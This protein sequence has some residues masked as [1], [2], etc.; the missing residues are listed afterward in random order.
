MTI[1]EAEVL[2]SAIDDCGARYE[3][4][5]IKR[6]E[7][8]KGSDVTDVTS[9]VDVRVHFTDERDW[10]LFSICS[11]EF[12]NRILDEQRCRAGDPRPDMADIYTAGGPFIVARSINAD[13][14]VRSVIRYLEIEKTGAGH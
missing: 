4:P 1:E 11:V 13:V 3:L 5:G 7:L 10:R 8:D 12:I 9:C 6:I 2:Q 14:I